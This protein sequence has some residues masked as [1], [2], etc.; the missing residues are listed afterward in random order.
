[1]KQAPFATTARRKGIFNGIVPI[2]IRPCG[3]FFK[4]RLSKGRHQVLADV[5]NRRHCI[6][7]CAVPADFGQVVDKW[8]LIFDT[9][10]DFHV[11]GNID[12]LVEIKQANRALRTAAGEDLDVI[13]MGTLHTNLGMYQ[14]RYGQVHEI[15]IEI[16]LEFL[17]LC[18]RVQSRGYSDAVHG[19]N[20]VM[21]RHSIR[22][23]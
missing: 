3:I 22:R 10:A 15:D 8:D 18:R 20:P 6:L 23:S 2:S 4:K 1:M 13:G 14:D 5:A 17:I 12:L 9:G 21:S 19:P 7:A 11:V 16:L